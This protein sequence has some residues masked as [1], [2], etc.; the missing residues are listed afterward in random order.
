MLI[1]DWSLGIMV[2]RDR[3]MGKR[4]FGDGLLG[5]VMISDRLCCCYS[6]SLKLVFCLFSKYYD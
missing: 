1:G 3:L 4:S 2:V 6:L 5:T